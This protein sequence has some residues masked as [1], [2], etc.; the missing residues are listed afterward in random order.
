MSAKG[1][2]Q[3]SAFAVRIVASGMSISIVSKTP[4]ISS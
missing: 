1:H 4:T 2:K 3:T